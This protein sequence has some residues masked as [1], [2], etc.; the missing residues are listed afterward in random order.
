LVIAEVSVPHGDGRLGLTLCPGK[1]D[2]ARHWD[3]DLETDIEVL[4]N[5]G[6]STVVT[7]IEA[8]EFDLLQVQPLGDCVQRHGMDWLHLPIVDVS[9]PDMR[10]ERGWLDCQRTLHQR[11][12]QGERIVI[13]CRGGLGRTGLVAG[14]IL[15]ERGLS[16]EAA[17]KRVRDARPHA[18]E[19]RRQEDYVRKTEVLSHH[20]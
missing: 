12:D 7:L 6:A 8:H 20:G 4:W 11:L 17:I 10:F 13:H 14:V 15:V 5:W 2:A 16:P 3:R 18:I 1:K 19:T 9:A